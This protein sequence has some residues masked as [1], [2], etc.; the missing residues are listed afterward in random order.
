MPKILRILKGLPLMLL[1]A[2]LLLGSAWT[3]PAAAAAAG[4]PDV[5]LILGDTSLSPGEAA[6]VPV[7]IVAARGVSSYNVQIEYDPAR[8]QVTGITPIYGN[9]DPALGASDPK[10]YFTSRIDSKEGTVRAA[11]LDTSAGSAAE[12]PLAGEQVLFIVEVKAV[13]PVG[14]TALKLPAGNSEELLFAGSAFGENALPDILSV[15]VTGGNVSVISASR[16][17]GPA[18]TPKPAAVKVYLNG[19]EQPSYAEASS[20]AD[21]SRTVTQIKVDNTKALELIEQENQS[22]LTLALENSSAD[23]VVGVLNGTLVKAMEGKGAEV[24]VKTAFASYVL[25]AKMIRIDKVAEQLK[26][27]DSLSDIAISVAM[28]EADAASASKAGAAAGKQGVALAATPVEFTVA[29]EYGGQRV[30]IDQFSGY[31]ERSIAV[32]AGVD[33]SKITTAAVLSKDG[34]LKHIPTRIVRETD[35]SYTAIINSMSN[36]LYTLIW[37]EASL[38]DLA[39]HWSRA[40]VS[41]LASRMIVQGDVQG[42]F[43]PNRRI[44]R[45]EF[46]AVLMRGL[47]LYNGE[48]DGKSA[49]LPKDVPSASWYAATVRSAQA[50]GLVSGYAD[51]SFQ[52]AASI[53]R[54]EAA[55][56]LNRAAALRG[57]VQEQAGAANV[58]KAYRD[59]G[60]VGAWAQQAVASAVNAG[61]IKGSGGELK[62]NADLTRAEAAA[63]IRRLLV[64]NELINS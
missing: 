24:E 64:Q 52:P 63:M 6:S 33:A 60:R 31:V 7:K 35:G 50:Y 53:S 59:G 39:K 32:P 30:N 29:A 8:I 45:A 48:S 9:A 11:W 38:T 62:P 56:I 46:A 25:P 5:R 42:R 55:A 23:R 16:D 58:L 2:A 43:Q 54:A 36:S 27:A 34:V 44:S 51:G 22:R 47:G 61:W 3:P 14:G 10:G 4:E 15:L 37:N 28:E 19:Q 12:H 17:N 1:A 21:G 41:D 57:G 18:A 26:A 49:A 20:K 13:G 40:D